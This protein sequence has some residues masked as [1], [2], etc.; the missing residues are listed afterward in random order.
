[1]AVPPLSARIAQHRA[2]QVAA[3]N[4][5]VAPGVAMRAQT[6][7]EEAEKERRA[8]AFRAAKEAEFIRR[9][10]EVAAYAEQQAR[11]TE[12]MQPDR[13]RTHSAEQWAA[14][15]AQDGDLVIYEAIAQGH[16]TASYARERGF[17]LSLFEE[18]CDEHLDRKKVLRAE[19]AAANLAAYDSVAL[20]DDPS[21]RHSMQ[22]VHHV[23]AHAQHKMT[24]AERRDAERWGPPKTVAPQPPPVA[25]VVSIDGRSVPDE[26]LALVEAKR[27]DKLAKAVPV[28]DPRSE[29]RKAEADE[30]E[31]V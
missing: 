27:A 3:V 25:L 13:V 6:E 7:R 14:L 26:H 10:E 31:Y 22:A 29:R 11:R 12:H 1:M 21:S 20:F 28:F 24:L 15:F 18:W 23:R 19:R 9:A 4:A 16:T 2:K 30:A 5:A 17:P 8:R